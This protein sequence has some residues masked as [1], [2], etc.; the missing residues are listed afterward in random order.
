M[1]KD[2]DYRA[3]RV[4]HEEAMYAPMLVGEWIDD[5]QST[6]R[7]LSVCRVNCRGVPDVD[8]EVWLGVL[9]PSWRN[10]ELSDGVGR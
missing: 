9:H 2:I 3:T 4:L 8:S 5:A 1:C 10:D 7:H 6:A